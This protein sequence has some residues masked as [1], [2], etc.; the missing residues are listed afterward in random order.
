[1]TELQVRTRQ[2]LEQLFKARGTSHVQVGFT[3][4]TGQLRGKYISRDKLL[5]GLDHG[6]PMTRNFAAVDFTDAIYPVEGLI[7]NGG[8]FGDSVARVVIE[9]CREVPWEPPEK[10][11]F[12]LIEHTGEG[13]EYD[14]RVLC[15]RMVEKAEAMGFRVLLSCELEF[16]LFNETVESLY[17]KDFKNLEL[18]TPV[19]NYLGVMRQTVWSEFFAEFVDAMEHL[20]IP[21]EVAH[22]ELAPGFAELVPAHAEGLRAADDAVI[23]KTFAKAFALRRG[24]LLSFMARYDAHSDGSSCHINLSLRDKDNNPVL[25]DPSAPHTLSENMRHFIGGMQYRMPE[26]LLMMAPNINSFKRFV[27]DIFAPVASSWGIDN[28]TT[29]LRV[30][31][32]SPQALRVE[33]RIPGADV[34]PYLAVACTLATGLWGIKN[35]IEPAA[36][37]KGNLYAELDNVPDELR[38]PASFTDAIA[39]FRQS[40][41]AREWFGEEF[42][43]FFSANKQEHELE[44][45]K[46]ITDW[47]LRRY[48]ELV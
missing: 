32:S 2:D 17:R 6:L 16:R 47:E 40:A 39:R 46:A 36:E 22:W 12:F 29:S 8:G 48:L 4:H 23:Y 20:G 42:V 30:I 14:P 31:N 24:L 9:S 19:S 26:V 27:P 45:R 34:N 38:F 25:H 1:M 33:N 35:R 21:I 44:Y 7:V 10:N 15:R 43:R 3:D 28:R 11:L 37:T 5:N 41:F 13:V 18:A